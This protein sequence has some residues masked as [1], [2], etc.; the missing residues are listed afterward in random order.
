MITQK[1]KWNNK[2]CDFKKLFEKFKINKNHKNQQEKLLEQKIM[3]LK[4]WKK[5][6]QEKQVCN[7]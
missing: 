1:D 2:I 3:L 7:L 6:S 5:V 4:D